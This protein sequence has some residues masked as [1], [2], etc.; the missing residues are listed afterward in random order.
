[1]SQ[2]IVAELMER[3]F[4][5]SRTLAWMLAPALLV[6]VSS[7]AVRALVGLDLVAGPLDTE[8]RG[9]VEPVWGVIGAAWL[10]A[11]WTVPLVV[12]SA[13]RPHRHRVFAALLAT[14]ASRIHLLAAQVL[15][16]WAT[17]VLALVLAVGAA[18][19]LVQLGPQQLDA[20]AWQE[21]IEA[22]WDDAGTPRERAAFANGSYGMWR[23]GIESVLERRAG[24]MAVSLQG[25]FTDLSAGDVEATRQA[26]IDTR[27]GAGT[28]ENPEPR[29]TVLLYA[30]SDRT[31]TS[32][33]TGVV[34]TVRS[35]FP[36]TD[37]NV[38]VLAVDADGSVQT[39]AGQALEDADLA[40]A[41]LAA[42]ARGQV[43]FD[44]VGP[45][46]PSDVEG[47]VLIAPRA[48]AGDVI[49]EVHAQLTDDRAD[50][51]AGTRLQFEN[52]GLLPGLLVT[53]LLLLPWTILIHGIATATRRGTIVAAVVIV[54]IGVVDAMV[55][56]RSISRQVERLSPR[57]FD[58]M[59]EVVGDPAPRPPGVTAAGGAAPT[60]TA[61]GGIGPATD[62][63]LSWAYDADIVVFTDV[64]DRAWS[65][66]IELPGLPASLMLLGAL[67]GA[68]AGAGAW[69][70]LR[71]DA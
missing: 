70:T 46:S 28:I 69:R 15:V 66:R 1:M 48:L 23:S 4:A 55:V 64:G 35:A 20:D 63:V 31:G 25:S 43:E 68:A 5:R 27:W 61:P 65:Y 29:A 50:L 44:H 52:R 71:S 45:A 11:V 40:A 59:D 34:D 18:A 42:D 10:V 47:F 21:R 3:W 19:G 26:W 38:H 37:L 16:A 32:D 62:R 60:V 24:A 7:L 67:V 56:E 2:A 6:L 14:G 39:L 22:A 17:V 30:P 33:P 53:A 8:T 58:A 49:P 9:L 12:S 51:E 57:A 54:A 41:A 13:R 36:A